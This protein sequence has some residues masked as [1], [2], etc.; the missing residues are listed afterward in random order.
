MPASLRVPQ[1]LTQDPQGQALPYPR[2]QQPPNNYPRAHGNR[3]QHRLR[4]RKRRR[5]VG[6]NGDFWLGCVVLHRNNKVFRYNNSKQSFIGR[7]NLVLTESICHTTGFE[8]RTKYLFY[9]K[10]CLT[11]PPLFRDAFTLMQFVNI[12]LS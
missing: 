10:T 3:N 4:R 9:S 12:A 6:E 7:L 1:P 5:G 8:M 2:Q 11:P